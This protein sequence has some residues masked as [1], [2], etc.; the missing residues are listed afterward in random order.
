MRARRLCVAQ[1]YQ[2]FQNFVAHAQELPSSHRQ[3][4]HLNGPCTLKQ[5]RD[6]VRVRFGH[7]VANLALVG[8]EV[9]AVDAELACGLFFGCTEERVKLLNY[10]HFAKSRLLDHLEILCNLQSAGNSSGPEVNIV[11]RIL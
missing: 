4:S 10:L 6:S 2:R 7:N 9:H 11:T 8:D 5:A 1:K 3:T